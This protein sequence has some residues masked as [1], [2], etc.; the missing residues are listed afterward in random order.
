MTAQFAENLIYHGE[1]YAL[2]AEPLYT[3]LQKRKNKHIRFRIPNTASTRGYRGTW[4]IIDDRLYLVNIRGQLQDKSKVTLATLFPESPGRIF[5]NWFTGEVRCPIGRLINYVHTGFSSV[6]ECDLFL[7][8]K[9]GVVMNHRKVNNNA[10]PSIDQ[11]P[12]LINEFPEFIKLV[13]AAKVRQ[14][15]SITMKQFDLLKAKFHNTM[16]FKHEDDIIELDWIDA[17][18]KILHRAFTLEGISVRE[19]IPIKLHR[20]QLES[21]GI[22]RISELEKKIQKKHSRT[23]DN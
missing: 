3:W 14:H 13:G 4:E 15:D 17:V 12:A 16:P 9:E 8:F 18:E 7:S 20:F 21:S 19:K 22:S 6:Y 23:G 10:L 5:A 1:T 2:A 11:L